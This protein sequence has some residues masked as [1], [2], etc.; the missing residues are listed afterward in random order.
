VWEYSGRIMQMTIIRT[1]CPCCLSAQLPGHFCTRAYRRTRDIQ[2]GQRVRRWQTSDGRR[3]REDRTQDPGH[4][5][6]HPCILS[7]PALLSFCCP[8]A[9][10]AKFAANCTTNCCWSML[11]KAANWWVVLGG[12]QEPR[13]RLKAGGKGQ[14]GQGIKLFKRLPLPGARVSE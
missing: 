3:Q 2:T 6:L 13:S 9:C 4:M 10:D 11:A 14:P 7:T 1:H 12:G 5:L 8:P